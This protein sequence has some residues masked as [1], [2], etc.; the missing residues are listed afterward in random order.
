MFLDFDRFKLINDSLGHAV[1]DE[2]LVHGGTPHPASPA[3]RTTFVARYGGDEFR[4]LAEGHRQRAL[5]GDAGPERCSR[6]C[7]QPFPHRRHRESSPARASA[8]RSAASHYLTPAEMLRDADIAMYKA[9]TSAR[10]AYAAVRHGAAHR[11]VRTA[12]GSRSD[13]RRA[14]AGDQLTV[15]IS[16]LFDLTTGRLNGFEALTRWNH[17]ELGAVSPMTSSSSPRKRASS[18]R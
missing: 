9:K 17:P 7:A 8:S 12:C 1:G 3:A 16:R 10:H 6:C 18:C 2:F 15:R 14:H 4:V 13:L 11:S 5:R